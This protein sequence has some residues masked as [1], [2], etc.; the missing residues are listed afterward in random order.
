MPD[1]FFRQTK[2][3]EKYFLLFLIFNFF[4]LQLNLREK[5][6]KIIFASTI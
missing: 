2:H 1:E 5:E 3:A 6:K 4:F